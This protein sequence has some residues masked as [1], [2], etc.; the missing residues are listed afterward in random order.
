MKCLEADLKTTNYSVNRDRFIW[1]MRNSVKKETSKFK[2]SLCK[3]ENQDSFLYEF[4]SRMNADGDYAALAYLNQNYDIYLME[5][6]NKSE[7]EEELLLK[8]IRFETDEKIYPI[9]NSYNLPKKVS[10]LNPK[11]ITKN[12]YNITILAG[13]IAAG[14]V[15]RYVPIPIAPMERK[16]EIKG[17]KEVKSEKE[18]WSSIFHITN[19]RYEDII[20]ERNL[21]KPSSVKKGLVFLDKLEKGERVFRIITD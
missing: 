15:L 8:D 5:V 16:E 18:Y 10:R 2:I 14:A 19:F 6:E 3:S 21:I 7:S 20:L 9:Y 4:Y 12:M 11:G 13:I 1:D 17:K